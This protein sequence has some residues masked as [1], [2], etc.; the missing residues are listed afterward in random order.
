MP[1]TVSEY[2]DD[3]SQERPE[4]VSKRIAAPVWY[5]A[6]AIQ[7]EPVKVFTELPSTFLRKFD[8][9][10]GYGMCRHFAYGDEPNEGGW[11]RQNKTVVGSYLLVRR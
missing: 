1:P 3:V 2:D 4:P 11:V 7:S 5:R 10:V 8:V 6:P 9:K